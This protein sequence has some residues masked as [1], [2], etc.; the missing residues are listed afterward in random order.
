MT[1]PTT[2]LPPR[3]GGY[4]R[5]RAKAWLLS[6]VG[7]PSA[8]VLGYLL[9]ARGCMGPHG[10]SGLFARY[11]RPLLRGITGRTLIVALRD[12]TYLSSADEEGTY[13][14]SAGEE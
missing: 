11:R 4:L 12:R 6:V 13:L 9:A 5:G 7:C 10:R 2:R 3:S 8:S 14:S 1:A